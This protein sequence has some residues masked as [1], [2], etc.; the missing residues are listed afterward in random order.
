M[1]TDKDGSITDQENII[2]KNEQLENKKEF[3]ESQSNGKEMS[4]PSAARY[5]GANGYTQRSNQKDQLENLH[6]GGDETHPQGGNEHHAE[7][8][9]AQGPGF[10]K[11]GSYE[12][13]NSIRTQDQDFGEDAPSGPARPAHD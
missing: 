12:M 13:G 3:D 2:P 5:T 9:N 11:E 6:I 8:E 1:A 7:G 4:D 10:T